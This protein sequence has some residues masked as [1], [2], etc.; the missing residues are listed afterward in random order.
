MT[1]QGENKPTQG[2]QHKK[3]SARHK[4]DA[5]RIGGLFAYYNSAI[6]LAFVLLIVV[7]ASYLPLWVYIIIIAPVLFSAFWFWFSQ[8]VLKT[9]SHLSL[10]DALV[11]TKISIVPFVV[12]FI[13]CL[14]SAYLS[15]YASTDL[16]WLKIFSYYGVLMGS[17]SVFLGMTVIFFSLR[18]RIRITNIK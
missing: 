5:W 9:H 16:N 7:T 15:F 1:K 6:V 3:S 8:Q 4:I 17:S 11:I 2:D 10:H 18:H 14:F 12:I 13:I